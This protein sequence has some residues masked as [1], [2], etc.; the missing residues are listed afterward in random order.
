[1]PH[2][3]E[4]LRRDV[5]P[6]LRYPARGATPRA[7]AAA[8]AARELAFAAALVANGPTRDLHPDAQREIARL[9][10]ARIDGLAE[11]VRAGYDAATMRALTDPLDAEIEKLTGL[12]EHIRSWRGRAAAEADRAE[13]V[14]QLAEGARERLATMTPTERRAVLDLRSTLRSRRSSS[15]ASCSSASCSWICKASA[16]SRAACRAPSATP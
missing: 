3:G 6:Q 8:V 13:Q 1:V 15:S 7:D 2:V 16:A 5:D 12:R 4:D 11:A 9:G 10:K 14:E